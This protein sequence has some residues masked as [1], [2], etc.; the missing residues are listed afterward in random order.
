MNW[1]K[2]SQ[3]QD[4]EN[5]GISINEVASNLDFLPTRKQAR[6]YSFF[7]INNGAIDGMPPMSYGVNDQESLKVVTVTSDGKETEN[8]AQNGDIVMSG[9]SAEKYVI[10]QAK[11]SKMYQGKIGEDVVPEQNPRMVAE[12]TGK[13]P[14]TFKAS[15]GEDM[16]LK[17]GDYLVK[18]GEGAYYRIAKKEYEQTY[19][20]PG[21]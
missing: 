8:T 12:Y 2:L 7:K 17:P 13:E 18:E 15:W 14:V 9:P 10:K 16:I 6:K 1:Y 5:T 11:F 21:L 3:S 4:G 20:P 19:N